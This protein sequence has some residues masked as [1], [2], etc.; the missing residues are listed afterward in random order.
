MLG[1]ETTR[2]PSLHPRMQ[3][4]V[5]T[6]KAMIRLY[7]KAHHHRGGNLCESC[8]EL[9]TYSIQRLANCPFQDKKT[10]CGAC[11]VH[12]YKPSMKKKVLDVMRYSGPRMML[13][14]PVL[15]LSHLL[16]E[17]RSINRSEE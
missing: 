9:Q 4:E 6:I 13:H 11:T 8:H 7:C 16:D 10:T 1:K 5:K 12:C 14:H 2:Q 17:K 15:A 3:R